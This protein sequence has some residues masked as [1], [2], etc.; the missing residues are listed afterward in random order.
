MA[1]KLPVRAYDVRVNW[2]GDT[3]VLVRGM[4]AYE[5]D[6]VGRDIWDKCDGESMFEDVAAAVAQE[7]AV[8]YETALADAKDFVRALRKSGLVT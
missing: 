1:E 4:E 6:D 3:M 8:A 5:L 2:V 7:Y